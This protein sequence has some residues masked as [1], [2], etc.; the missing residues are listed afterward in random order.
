MKISL[1]Q[2]IHNV[3]DLPS[4]PQVVEQVIRITKDPE[5]TARELNEVI[6]Q[7]QVLTARVLRL[8][9]SAYY[10]FARRITTV[11]EAIIIL[12]FNTIRNLVLTAS[13]HDLLSKEVP[14]Y[15]L[16]KGEL[17]YH[18]IACAMTARMLARQVGFPDSDQA[19]IAGLLHDLGKVVLSIYVKDTYREIIEKLQKEQISFSQAEQQIL[20]FT[21]AEVGARIA[22]KWNFPPS[23][24]EAIAYHHQ[25]DS[26]RVNPQLTAIIHIADAICLT[27]GIGLGGDGL[28]YPLCPKAFQLLGLESTI[29][30]EL[31]EKLKDI[32]IDE[33]S[34]LE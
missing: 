34:F 4:L 29:I 30:E 2:I 27:M 32:F 31:M 1:E 33:N 14:G 20:G 18:S 22:E 3:D 15:Q 16:G 9:N 21:H 7:D 6:C 24:V 10:G 25:P 28:C 12:G 5:S 8:A 23:L 13:V 11:I 26:A 19:Y 17:W